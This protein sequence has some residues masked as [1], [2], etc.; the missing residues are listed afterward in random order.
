MAD[1]NGKITVQKRPNQ[2]GLAHELIH[3]ERS[4]RG[5]AIDKSKKGYNVIYKEGR[6]IIESLPLEEAATIGLNN[7]NK[8]DITE[9]EIREEQG[10]LKRAAYGN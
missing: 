9:N 2:I 4:S 6:R 1:K 3:A 8:N 5:D 7:T 10:E